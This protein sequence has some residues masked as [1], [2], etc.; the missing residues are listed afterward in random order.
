MRR[1][2][3]GGTVPLS[4][5]AAAF[6]SVGPGAKVE[7]ERV[8]AIFTS[9]GTESNRAVQPYLSQLGVPQ[10]FVGDGSR[11]AARPRQ[12]PWTMGFLQSHRGEG[13]RVRPHD[14]PHPAAG[15]PAS[16]FH[17]PRKRSR[18]AIA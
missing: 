9:V 15:A 3:L 4:G 1:L 8:F 16:P 10:L 11:A 2:A 13:A 5:E 17:A 12:Y 6:G 18:R 14:R 7:Q